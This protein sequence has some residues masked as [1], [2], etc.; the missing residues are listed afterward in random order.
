MSDSN[1]AWWAVAAWSVLIALLA[2]LVL[3][4][5]RPL[6]Q[7]PVDG[8]GLNWSAGIAER[9]RFGSV[10]NNT[11]WI[12]GRLTGFEDV[13][14]VTV[15]TKPLCKY[16]DDAIQTWVFGENQEE[17]WFQFEFETQTE[18]VGFC[19]YRDSAEEIELLGGDYKKKWEWS[20]ASAELEVDDPFN[21][22]SLSALD[23]RADLP[24]QVYTDKNG[25]IELTGVDVDLWYTG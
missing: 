23:R 10:E 16:A 19:I 20:A 9:D 14:M 21:G 6:E 1:V 13:H 7:G 8:G 11:V 24:V 15:R 3:V 25:T 12:E 4:G 18:S 5:E 17:Y 22:Y 2:G